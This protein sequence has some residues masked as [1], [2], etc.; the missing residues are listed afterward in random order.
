[1]ES[2]GPR[3]VEPPDHQR[4]TAQL[5]L[6]VAGFVL[7]S[8]ALV[9][10]LTNVHFGDVEF[11]GWS[12]PLGT[13]LLSGDVPYRDFTLP[14]P[15]GSFALVALIERVSGRALLSNELWLNAAIHALL[16]CLAYA[17]ARAF[18]SR[19]LALAVAASTLVAMTYLNKECA[20]D[21]TAQLTAWASLVAAARALI[22][23]DSRARGRWWIAAGVAAGATLAFKQSTALG[24]LA[25]LSLG[26]TYAAWQ[27]Q[28]AGRSGGAA[29]RRDAAH[30]AG[31]AVVGLALVAVLLVGL[32]A[33]PASFVT[34]V[35]RDGSTLKGGSGRL[36]TNVW[37]YFS[38]YG[39]FPPSL[40]FIVALAAVGAGVHRSGGFDLAQEQD[41]RDEKRTAWAVALAAAA[42]FVFA[43]AWLRSGAAGLGAAWVHRL[44]LLKHLPGF[45]VVL[46][47]GFVALGPTLRAPRDE[48]PNRARHRTGL[49][50]VGAMALVTTILH[51][52]SAPE[53]RP[54]Y[55]NNVLIPVGF[56]HLYVALARCGSR[57]LWSVA[58]T[59]A[60]ASLFGN[61][62]HRAAEARHAAPQE[63]HWAGLWV[64]ERGRTMLRAAARVRSLTNEDDTVLVLPEDLQLT[65]LIGRR[66]PELRGAIAFV[67]QYPASVLE[68]DVSVLER[69]PPKVI[70]VHPREPHQWVRFYRIWAVESPAE[71]LLRHVLASVLPTK[72]ERRY[73]FD[74]RFQHESATLD[75][76]VRRE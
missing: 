39:V 4:G 65:S 33:S 59:L 8:T 32:G 72:Y 31:G 18:T 21:H 14:I 66:R 46:A 25:A 12:G 52:T 70:V 74:T 20:Y 30:V 10:R 58:F 76:W 45:G 3:Q 62:L 28:R 22:S 50:A 63:G 24:A 73:S 6:V 27:A 5:A 57:W 53:F 38:S 54:F 29:L 40:G 49:E 35:F 42:T 36:I 75:V 34:A 11:S 43:F 69:E 47:I 19:A 44:D 67:D 37:G 9:P 13:R 15:P 55:D 17:L 41:R 1:M 68:H 71:R 16:G 23:T 48:A 7:L 61:K 60:L 2:T 56:L 51:N 26:P 64:S